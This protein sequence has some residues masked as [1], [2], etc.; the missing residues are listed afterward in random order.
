MVSSKLATTRKRVLA[1]SPAPLNQFPLLSD[2]GSATIRRYG[3]LNTV[4]EEAL[5]L[6]GEEPAVRADLR[7]YATVNRT[8]RAVQRHS[9]SW[10]VHRESTGTVHRA[11]R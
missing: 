4:V 3:I 11:F 7:V 5:G 10:H 1:P 2:S 9:V 8:E 6:N